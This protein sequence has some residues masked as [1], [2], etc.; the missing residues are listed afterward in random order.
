[1]QTETGERR[2]VKEDWFDEEIEMY[3]QDIVYRDS[4]AN[5]E[6]YAQGQT[7]LLQMR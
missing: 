1:M 3:T 5:F 4:A 6:T 2:V 7:I